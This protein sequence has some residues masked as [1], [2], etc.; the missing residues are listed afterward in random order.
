MKIA[1]SSSMSVLDSPVDPNY[2]RA[3]YFRI[4]DLK[5]SSYDSFLN[6]DFKS[7]DSAGIHKAWLFM[8]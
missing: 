6:P 2:E 4:V 7:S 5:S 8:Y 3:D 1:V